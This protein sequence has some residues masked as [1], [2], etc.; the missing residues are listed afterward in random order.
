[1]ETQAPVKTRR[2]S[3]ETKRKI[4]ESKRRIE[5]PIIE[6]IRQCHAAGMRT[7]D[8]AVKFGI[9]SDCISE[10]VNYRSYTF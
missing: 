7:K 4:Q 3:A 1:M 8:L 6:A 9:K 5:K 10:I 2:H